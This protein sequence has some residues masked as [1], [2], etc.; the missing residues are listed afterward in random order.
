MFKL[1]LEKAEESEIKLRDQT[2]HSGLE[3][4]LDCI[5][6]EVAKSLTEQLSLSLFMEFSRQEY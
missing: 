1:D 3:N 5:V 6:Q 2:R 4:S